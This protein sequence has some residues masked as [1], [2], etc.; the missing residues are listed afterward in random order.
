MAKGDH[1]RAYI[2]EAGMSVSL[3]RVSAALLLAVMGCTGGG[4]TDDASI[5]RSDESLTTTSVADPV[6]ASEPEPAASDEATD[7]PVREGPRR[8][9]TNSVPHIQLDAE[10]VPDVDVEMRRRLFS[11]PSV[12]DRDTVISLAGT[13]GLWLADD[14][15]LERP[16]ILLSGRE[17]AH[18]HPDG[19][20]HVWMPVDLAEEMA[21]KKW[22]ELHPWVDRD[23]F[24]DG[25]VMI[26]TPETLEE[27]DVVVRLVV[28]AYNYV[29]GADLRPDD[30]G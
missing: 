22:G 5:S 29:T 1:E 25:V 8:E 4:S 18:I 24:W 26:Y 13:R 19:S 11:L 2:W 27:V 23:D 7:L 10:P 28:E 16:E 21:E 12:E 6:A 20:L 30:V 3:P 15:A 9:T 14:L 17:F